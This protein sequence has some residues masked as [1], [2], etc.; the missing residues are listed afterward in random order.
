MPSHH[1]VTDEIEILAS[2]HAVWEVLTDPDF[3]RLWDDVPESYAGGRLRLGSILEWVLA[4][5]R[6]IKELAEKAR[7]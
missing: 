5:K 6:T 2:R 3:I 1:T 7:G 4:A